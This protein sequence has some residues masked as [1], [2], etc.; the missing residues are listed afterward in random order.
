MKRKQDSNSDKIYIEKMNSLVKYSNEVNDQDLFHMIDS[1][2][3]AVNNMFIATIAQVQEKQDL[4][5]HFNSE[6]LREI[7][8]Y[9][10]NLSKKDFA[11]MVQKAFKE[12]A[13]ITLDY[14]LVREDGT[15]DKITATLFSLA[16]VNV[17]RQ[18][19]TVQ[20]NKQY[21]QLLN[22]L[23][24]WSRYSLTQYINIHSKYSK[25]IF[26]LLKQY[27][28]TGIRKFDIEEFRRFLNVPEYFRM[29]DIN[30]RIL[31]VAIEELAPYFKN[32]SI[33]KEKKGRTVVRIIFS[34]NSEGNSQKNDFIPIK[35]IAEETIGF[36]NI[37][38]NPNMTKTQ[39]YRAIDRYLAYKLGTTATFMKKNKPKT[40]FI[41]ANKKSQRG[42]NRTDLD[43]AY[44]LSIEK[45]QKL[46]EIY[47]TFN[48]NNTLEQGDIDDLIKLELILV[49]KE[50]Q[51][52]YKSI[53]NQTGN[54]KAYEPTS[55]LIATQVANN[56]LF[57]DKKDFSLGHEK[58]VTE[59]V[60]NQTGINFAETPEKNK[61]F[62]IQTID[63]DVLDV[64]DL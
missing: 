19:C 36:F 37:Q 10:K 38:R 59:L 63:S 6:Q 49:N 21:V 44:S 45:L 12:M 53:R 31:N 30:S 27:R 52:I 32:L 51:K 41:I 35:S 8:G 29:T 54:S 47:E 20:L 16:S 11:E 33:K 5:V 43:I 25:K 7:I 61:K 64:F 9:S 15:T 56:R 4:E 3:E 23:T 50:S 48:K 17:E 2:S 62:D 18:E 60:K 55:R 24:R 39:K 13:K 34:F 28:T 1:Y 22:N 58:E 42:F 46:V 40:L 57:Y 14:D 26:R